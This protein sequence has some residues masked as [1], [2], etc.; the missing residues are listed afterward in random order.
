MSAA[1]DAILAS[2]FDHVV[3]T[4]GFYLHFP[5][6]LMSKRTHAISLRVGLSLLHM[7]HGRV[8][9]V[10]GLDIAHLNRMRHSFEKN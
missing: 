2:S 3:S 6:S 1:H 4:V 9:R 7:T 10:A 8:S 5:S